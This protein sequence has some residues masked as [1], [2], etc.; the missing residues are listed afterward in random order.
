VERLGDVIRVAADAGTTV[1]LI[2]HNFSFVTKV[3]DV[4]HA[5]H[6]GELIA[7]GP[8]ATIGDNQRVIDSYLGPAIARP[9][10]VSVGDE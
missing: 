4:V 2:E 1:L 3:S 6:A 9:L 5:L 10:T 7:S 8:A